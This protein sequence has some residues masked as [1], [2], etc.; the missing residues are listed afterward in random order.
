MMKLCIFAGSLVM[1][2]VFGYL[3][4]GLG[5]MWEIVISGIGSMVGVYAGWKFARWLDR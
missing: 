4:T 5:I 3:A 2:Y 1:G